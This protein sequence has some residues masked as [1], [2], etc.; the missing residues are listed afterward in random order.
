VRHTHAVIETIQDLALAM[1]NVES[2]SRGFVLSG[3][4]SD[5]IAYRSNVLKAE[6]DQATIRT[7]TADNPVQQVHF[8]TVE[9]L[10]TERIQHADMII[11]LR[12]NE[13]IDAAVTAIGLGP[14]DEVNDE[15]QAVIVRMQDEEL[16]L[17]AI[18]MTE[19]DRDRDQTRMVLIVGTLLGILVAGLAAWSAVRD[20]IRRRGSPAAKRRKIPHAPR[21]SAGLCHLHARSARHRGQLERQCRA[22]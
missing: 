6:Q 2:A 21:R 13:G 20:S 11:G 5:L 9:T 10:A 12:R 18:R 22:Y 15:F 7:L 1:E 16:R 4:E 14:D 17:L 8:P 19:A 3:K